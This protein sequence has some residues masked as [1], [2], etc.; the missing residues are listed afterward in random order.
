MSGEGE[1]ESEGEDEDEGEDK[2]RIGARA[3]L[4]VGAMGAG[5]RGRRQ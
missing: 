5:E 3:V 1:R 2:A 4:G